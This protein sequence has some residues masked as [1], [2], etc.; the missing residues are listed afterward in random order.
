M[1]IRPL[2]GGLW[3][4]LALILLLVQCQT[5]EPTVTL[6]PPQKPFKQLSEYGFFTGKLRDLNPN[7][8]VLPY[9][10]ITPLFTDYAHK[11]RFVWM[12]TGQSATVDGE[13]IIQFPEGTAIIKNFYYPADFNKPNAQ[14]NRIETRLLVKLNNAWEAHSYVWDEEERDAKLTLVGDLQAVHWVD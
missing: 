4:T 5:A 3:G 1:N 12:P 9:D 7:E 8:G 13:G 6:A 14:I 11:S 2:F 10:L